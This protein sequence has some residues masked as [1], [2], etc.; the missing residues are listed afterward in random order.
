MALRNPFPS[1]YSRLAQVMSG[2]ANSQ[3]PIETGWELAGRLGAAYGSQRL[4]DRVAEDRYGRLRSLAEAL[5]DSRTGWEGP[6]PR[7]TRDPRD[8]G[9][10]AMA[11]AA[12][13]TG[14]VPW[15]SGVSEAPLPGGPYDGLA[16]M[17]AGLPQDPTGMG[18]M[19]PGAWG[20]VNSALL[21]PSDPAAMM[22]EGRLYSPPAEEP[23]LV[24]TPAGAS[25]PP[26]FFDMPIDEGS[27]ILTAG[28]DPIGIRG[29]NPGN[30]RP[31]GDQWQGMTGGASSD[32]SGDFITFDTPENGIRAMAINLD[33]QIRRGA[34][35]PL[36]LMNVL[37]PRGD[38]MDRDGINNPEAYA[39]HVAGALGIGVN[40][41]I[42]WGD[43]AAQEALVR[44]IIQMENGAIPYAPEQVAGGMAAARTRMAE[45]GDAPMAVRTVAGD[46]ETA[47]TEVM[48]GEYRAPPPSVPNLDPRVRQLAQLLI[49]SP[50]TAEMGLNLLVQGMM[51]PAAGEPF[52]LGEDQVRYGADGR[53]IARGPAG[54]PDD[55][56]V[57]SL[58][59]RLVDETGRVIY[60]GPAENLPFSGTS[61]DAQDSNILLTGD[62]ASREYALAYSRQFSPRPIMVP[63]PNGTMMQAF[64]APTPPE[65]IRP[66][67]SGAAQPAAAGP[68]APPAA[69]G[70]PPAGAGTVRTGGVDITPVAGS[71]RQSMSSMDAG[72]AALMDV[73]LT[74][75]N[76][77]ISSIFPNGLDGDPDYSI[78]AQANIP[79]IGGALPW[80]A[81]QTARVAL[82][83]AIEARLRAESGA[84]VPDPEVVRA[85]M[86][87]LPSATDN[88]ETARLKMQNV[89]QFIESGRQ[90]MG[91]NQTGILPQPGAEA[92]APASD[93]PY[94]RYGLTPP[95][96]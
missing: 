60:E 6:D 28:Q 20:G 86:R 65:G 8:A 69:P 30:L 74:N 2:Y 94:L 53:E 1:Q 64:W 85:H 43:P 25:L 33:T 38:T 66:P 52:T 47:P 14:A 84:A 67:V 15:S 46:M 68:G 76:S 40:D 61:M 92:P 3:Q 10:D 82:Q 95:A 42:P 27:V 41:T 13:A 80:S 36:A 55:P 31:S 17:M 91:L 16:A 57:Y 35:T 49:Q 72:R 73:A 21:Q 5:M 81:G 59:G 56:S 44:S 45:R 18:E 58:G 24:D 26:D 34:D 29:N 19:D 54:R 7:D 23:A 12:G 78:I 32:A 71:E 88:P 93:D 77:A 63:G 90:F 37:A 50:D 11:G 75:I 62:P 89:L 9:A 4:E 22:G 83:E 48:G 87:M 79:G 39:E 51:P 70:A 96:R